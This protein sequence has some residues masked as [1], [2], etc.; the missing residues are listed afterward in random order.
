MG[1]VLL[2]G[3]VLGFLGGEA[4]AQVYRY[5]DKNGVVH[6][7]DTPPDKKFTRLSDEK[8]AGSELPYYRSNPQI[9]RAERKLEIVTRAVIGV[10]SDRMRGAGFLINPAGYAVTNHHV[11]ADGGSRVKAVTYDGKEVSAQVVATDPDR[12]LALLSLGVSGYPYLP[13]GKSADAVVGGEV[14]T[15]GD[16]LGLSQSVSRGI[17]SGVRRVKLRNQVPLTLIQT[18]AAINPGN[19]GGPLVSPEGLVLGVVTLKAGRPN[20]PVS[21]I[22]FAVSGEDIIA[23]LGLTPAKKEGSSA[24]K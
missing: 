9:E 8:F 2:G 10:K 4:A 15:I 11:I 14:F 1:L 21:G 6:F 19:S 20:S 7:T 17:V 16:P 5:K 13:L 3:T 18:D 23:G 22:G 24:E 12:D